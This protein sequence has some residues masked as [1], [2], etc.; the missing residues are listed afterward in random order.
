[1]GRRHVEVVV[2]PLALR[3]AEA[4]AALG[5]SV[6]TFDDHVR[7]ALPVVRISGV[8]VYPLSG[9]QAWLA[10][11]EERPAGDRVRRAA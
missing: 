9:L 7:P 1:M 11:H 3:R 8:V 4:A 5:L 2:P 10:R 6:E